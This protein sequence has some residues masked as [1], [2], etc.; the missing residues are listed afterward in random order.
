MQMLKNIIPKQEDSIVCSVQWL[1]YG[2]D[3]R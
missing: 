3:V 1:G 2:L